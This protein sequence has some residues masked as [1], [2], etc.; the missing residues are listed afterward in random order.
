MHILRMMK[1]DFPLHPL[2]PK[3]HHIR[4]LIGKEE[5]SLP[6]ACSAFGVKCQMDKIWSAMK[7]WIIYGIHKSQNKILDKSSHG[8]RNQMRNE[9]S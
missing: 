1:K 3:T 9:G 4:I 2:C 5:G 8:L 7:A 6:G